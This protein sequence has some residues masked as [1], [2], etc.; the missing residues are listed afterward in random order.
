MDET[1]AARVHAEAAMMM[2]Q[3]LT[4]SLLDRGVL[5]SE[6]VLTAL[7]DVIEAQHAADGGMA[8][9][10]SVLSALTSATK[11]GERAARGRPPS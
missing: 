8:F 10:R 9:E 4:L 7:E 6:D 5:S 2:L 1:T 3:A 11:R